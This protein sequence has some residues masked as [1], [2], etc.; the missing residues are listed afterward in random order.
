MTHAGQVFRL[1]VYAS[2]GG[3]VEDYQILNLQT[4]DCPV[5]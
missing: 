3:T 2:D 5:A 1:Y 4:A